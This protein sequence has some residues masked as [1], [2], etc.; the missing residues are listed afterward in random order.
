MSVLDKSV[1]LFV[2]PDSQ[3]F[4]ISNALGYISKI[5][6]KYGIPSPYLV[7]D[8]ILKFDPNEKNLV[9]NLG[10][11]SD[12]IND[13]TTSGF[14]VGLGVSVSQQSIYSLSKSI[15]DA[16]TQF[17]SIKT[18]FQKPEIDPLVPP[19]PEP[20]PIYPEPEPEPE[21]IPPPPI[22][23]ILE[24]IPKDGSVSSSPRTFQ[25]IVLR[26]Q[27]PEIYSEWV[28]LPINKVGLNPNN[29]RNQIYTMDFSP[30]VESLVYTIQQMI[31]ES[32]S[33][34]YTAEVTYL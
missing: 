27:F 26:N 19:E 15:G 9:E 4:D 6:I 23:I 1:S 25:M 28:K 12:E 3:N 5:L 29:T 13:N 18:A 17:T 11:A 30:D 20:E 10:K 22:S 31:N 24:I 7:T 21:P 14:S 34:P 33:M 8:S 32:P 2:Y 16:I